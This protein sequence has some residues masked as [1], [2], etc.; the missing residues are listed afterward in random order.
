MVPRSI[1][2]WLNITGQTSSRAEL[3]LCTFN[4]G[5]HLETAS[6]IILTLAVWAFGP[7]V[8]GLGPGTARFASIDIV[9]YCIIL[10]TTRAQQGCK[11]WS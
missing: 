9:I 3:S 6:L 8:Q 10:R 4:A 1:W 2:S 11:Q 5:T 7:L